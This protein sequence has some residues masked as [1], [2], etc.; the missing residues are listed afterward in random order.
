LENVEY[1]DEEY[2]KWTESC[3]G[4]HLEDEVYIEVIK[5]RRSIVHW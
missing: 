2:E 4:E 3:M 5:D 1:G